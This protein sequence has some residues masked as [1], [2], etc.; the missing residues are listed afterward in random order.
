MK[1][2]ARILHERIPLLMRTLTPDNQGGYDEQWQELGRFWVRVIP[3]YTQGSRGDYVKSIR[4]GGKEI[5]SLGYKIIVN[6]PT[7]KKTFHRL[8]WR[9]KTLALTTLP[10]VDDDRRFA[11][12]YASEIMASEG[13][14]Q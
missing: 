7:A 14:S 13:H 5:Q 12:Y 10:E 1:T 3:L 4:L 8:L 6:A 9:G 11:L 2:S